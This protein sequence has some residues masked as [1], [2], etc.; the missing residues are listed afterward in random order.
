[1]GLLANSGKRMLRLGLTASLLSVTLVTTSGL[2]AA[3]TTLAAGTPVTEDFS[4]GYNGGTGWNDDWDESGDNNSS[5]SGTIEINSSNLRFEDLEDDSISRTLD[6][7]TFTQGAVFS[8]TLTS[9]SGDEQLRFEF[10]T[11]GGGTFTEIARSAANAPDGIRYSFVPTPAMIRTNAELRIRTGPDNWSVS[12]SIEINDLGIDNPVPNPDF[13]AACGTDVGLVLDESGSIDNDGGDPSFI[14]S[15]ESAVTAFVDGL[16]GPGSKMRITE[17]SNNGRDALIGGTTAFHPVDASFNTAVQTYL[18]TPNQNAPEPTGYDPGQGQNYTNWQAG[19]EASKTP[20]STAPGGIGAPLVVLFTD[21][22]TN[23]IG[24][25]D[26]GP[27]SSPIPTPQINIIKTLTDG[28]TVTAPGSSI[29]TATYELQID[30]VGDRHGTYDLADNPGFA[31]GLTITD[32]HST[33][34]DVP[35][36]G[37]F[38]TALANTSIATGI[39]IGPDERHLVEVVVTFAATNSV[40]PADRV[41]GQDPGPGDA[42]FNAT[43]VT[44]NTGPPSSDHACGPLPDPLHTTSLIRHR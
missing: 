12:D 6:L 39:A 5:G 18:T 38:N 1:L 43:T 25:P 42:T 2:I 15:V 37:D 40:G 20:G 28:P 23:N 19:I 36:N 13:A 41:C 30:N 17:F 29:W 34:T 31:T 27:D 9:E 8:Y 33:S 32:H 24:D 22:N 35:M 26:S 14:T 3:P 16:D 44:S 10:R 11:G 7:S 21:G 4:S